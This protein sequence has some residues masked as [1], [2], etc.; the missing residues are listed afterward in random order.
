[1][2]QLN[3]LQIKKTA[4]KEK[5]L[6]EYIKTLENYS[7]S[8]SNMTLL[9]DKQEELENIRK[10]KFEGFITRTRLQWLDEREILFL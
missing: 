9:A 10:Q 2:K 8:Q 4:L 6:L 5:W 7:V 1:M 3:L